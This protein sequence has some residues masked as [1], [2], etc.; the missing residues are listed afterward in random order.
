[1]SGVPKNE[2]K[3]RVMSWRELA[4]YFKMVRKG[5]SEEGKLKLKQI[6]KKEAALEDLW[7]EHSKAE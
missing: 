3:I 1:M 5:L 6:E 2:I 7:D 4:G